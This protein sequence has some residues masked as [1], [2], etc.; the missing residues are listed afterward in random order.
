MG[1]LTG[2]SLS[3]DK[4]VSFAKIL[5]APELHRGIRD[6]GRLNGGFYFKNRVGEELAAPCMEACRKQYVYGTE[7]VLQNM[8]RIMNHFAFNETPDGFV[9]K[10]DGATDVE[11]D[12]TAIF[13]RGWAYFQSWLR[14]PRCTA[15]QAYMRALLAV[16]SYKANRP[17]E[18]WY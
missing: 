15:A 13:K 16:L 18:H 2:E 3:R 17:Y 6:K 12:V 4:W 8:S 5:S 9:S 7:G 14:T 11:P 10:L 1:R